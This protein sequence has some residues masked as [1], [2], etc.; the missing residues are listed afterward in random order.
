MQLCQRPHGD[1]PTMTNCLRL[2]RPAELLTQRQYLR[3]RLLGRPPLGD[4]TRINPR[5]LRPRGMTPEV[6]SPNQNPH[7]SI[8]TANTPRHPPAPT[9]RTTVAETTPRTRPT[10]TDEEN[11]QT[12][13]Q[14]KARNQAHQS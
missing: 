14:P 12:S 6:V 8:F 4:P 2:E 5:R 1:L 11:K 10:A 3:V 7:P 13:E 9:D